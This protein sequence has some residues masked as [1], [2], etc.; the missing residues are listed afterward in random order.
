MNSSDQNT[1]KDPSKLLCT[2][3]GRGMIKMPSCSPFGSFILKEGMVKYKDKQRT[4][5]FEL[6]T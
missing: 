4:I 5:S 1:T 2:V 3:K 6:F